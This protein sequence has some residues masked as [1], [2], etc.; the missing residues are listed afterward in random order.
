MVV[1]EFQRA[2]GWFGEYKGKDRG[3]S[4]F[5]SLLMLKGLV[6]KNVRKKMRESPELC[7]KV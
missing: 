2:A 1:R 3:I 6:L 7:R 4:V 5:L